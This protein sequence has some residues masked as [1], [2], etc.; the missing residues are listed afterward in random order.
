MCHAAVVAPKNAESPT[1]RYKVLHKGQGILSDKKHPFKGR[2]E[3]LVA[4]LEDMERKA[5]RELLG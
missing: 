2:K 5:G 1:S 3:A 4:L